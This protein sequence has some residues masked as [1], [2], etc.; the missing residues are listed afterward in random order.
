M[1]TLST[2]TFKNED[3]RALVLEDKILGGWRGK[4]IGG[5]LGLP[6]E[7]KR[8]RLHLRFYDP[9]PTIA[10]PND[11]L[12]LQLVWLDLMERHAG[13]LTAEAI[14]DAWKNQIHYVWDEYGRARWNLRR[15]IPAAQ[16]GVFEN[17]FMSCM[18]SAIRSEVWACVAPGNPQLAARF[19]ILDSRIDHG[20]EGVAG[21]LFFTVLESLI[22]AGSALRPAV[23]EAFQWVDRDTETHRALKFVFTLES[24]QVEAWAARDELLKAHD[25]LNFTHAPLNVALTLWALLYGREDF[26]TT[27]LLAVNAGY[28]TDCTAATAGAVL[29]MLHGAANLPARWLAPVG[30]SVA[31]GPGIIGI[32]APADLTELTRRCIALQSRAQELNPIEETIAPLPVLENLAGTVYLVAGNKKIAWAN[33]ELPDAVKK[34]KGAAWQW[35]PRSGK[36][37]PFR[38]LCM[39]PRGARLWVDG[40]LIIDCPA[41][42]PHIPATHRAPE[43]TFATYVPTRDVHEIRVELT[44]G[45]SEPAEVILADASLHLAPWT[46]ADLPF[47]PILASV[48]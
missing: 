17:P 3:T 11:D 45:A 6:T 25:H 10:P 13:P 18:G 12:E 41:G 33:G 16:C 31:V 38:L 39:A 23:N 47:Q 46:G 37:R 9:V 5:T 2:A 26:E 30:D 20:P 27:V 19:A 15:G 22:L 21:E 48:L 24:T 34:N 1:N 28:D 40:N 14:G 35:T 42:L 44:S 8:E 43:G 7:G 29:G 4:S 36:G 32:N